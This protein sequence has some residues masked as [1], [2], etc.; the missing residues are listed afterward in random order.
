MARFFCGRVR[1]CQFFNYLELSSQ[2]ASFN[3]LEG[4][5]PTTS[6]AVRQPRLQGQ[7]VA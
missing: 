3:S 1:G 6:V 7:G 2:P 4:F 5:K